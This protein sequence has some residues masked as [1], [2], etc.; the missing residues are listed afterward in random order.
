MRELYVEGDLLI[1]SRSDE[2]LAKLVEQR[3]E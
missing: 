1:S 3:P 2:R